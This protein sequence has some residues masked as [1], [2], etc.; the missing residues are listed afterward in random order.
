MKREQERR[1][2]VVG[3]LSARPGDGVLYGR[4]ET[5]RTSTFTNR[6]RRKRVKSETESE[7]VLPAT[8]PRGDVTERAMS[9]GVKIY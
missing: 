3:C 2:A 8:D 7:D 1:G 5:M 6:E 9:K 4:S